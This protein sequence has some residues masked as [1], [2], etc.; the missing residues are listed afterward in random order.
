MKKNLLFETIAD[1]AYLAGVYH[2]YSGDSR[3][4][5]QEFIFLA[6]EFE[7][8]HQNTN[9]EDSDF[10]Y[11]TEIEKFTVENLKLKTKLDLS[12]FNSITDQWDNI[13]INRCREDE[14]GN[15]EP[16]YDENDIQPNDFWSVYL[17]QVKGGVICIA[18]L[19]T[20]EMGYDL[21][22]LLQYAIKHYKD[23][24]YLINKLF[25]KKY[26]SLRMDIEWEGEDDIYYDEKGNTYC[27]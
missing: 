22:N 12:Y 6:K 14:N 8:H 4:D 1:I 16:V 15:V 21:A 23:N 2:Y 9:W 3:A 11:M 5:I 25:E 7:K 18:D 20:E 13:E 10:D 19:P 26:D 17:H 27:G 24:G